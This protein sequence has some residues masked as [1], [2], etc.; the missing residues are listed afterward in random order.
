MFIRFKLLLILFGEID[1]FL[2][3]IFHFLD[4]GLDVISEILLHFLNL[5]PYPL[6]MAINIAKLLLLMVQNTL[7]SL[8]QIDLILNAE[9]DFK[10]DLLLDQL[11]VLLHLLRLLEVR[12]RRRYLIRVVLKGQCHVHWVALAV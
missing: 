9:I 1:E 7:H 5:R 10:L 11:D 6:E 4:L 3:T 12:M 2:L 8:V